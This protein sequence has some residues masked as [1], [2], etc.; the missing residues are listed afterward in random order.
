MRDMSYNQLMHFIAN[1]H[2]RRTRADLAYTV[3]FWLFILVG[4]NFAFLKVFEPNLSY[5]EDIGFVTLLF[6]FGAVFSLLTRLVLD[7]KLS[8][9]SERISK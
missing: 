8:E 1:A 6:A 4:V 9:L 3:F 5:L 7:D 2:D